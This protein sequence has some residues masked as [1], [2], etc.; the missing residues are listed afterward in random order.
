M[1]AATVLSVT[2]LACGLVVTAAAQGRPDPAAMLAAEK[3]AMAPLA[4]MDGVWRGPAWSLLPTGEK[5]TIT[6]TER[7]G[8]FLDSSVKV[9]EGRGYNTDG[10]VGFNAFGTISFDP[11]TH[12]YT[13]HAY[14]QGNAGDFPLVP[15][16]DGYTW[17]IPSGPTTTIRYTAT[18]ANGHWLEVGDQITTGQ[19]PVRIFEM[20]LVRVGNTNWPAAGA[21]S[22]Q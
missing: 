7:I 14:A 15:S 3:A 18:I 17:T 22:R 11:A 9:T 13:L 6:Q 12:A 4:F 19:A 16:A 5:H 2:M 21:I 10:S 1:T 8:P 20:R